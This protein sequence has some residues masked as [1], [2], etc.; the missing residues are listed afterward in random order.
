MITLNLIF[1]QSGK[2]AEE[3]EYVSHHVRSKLDE[4][5]RIELERLR[6]LAKQQYELT[7]GKN[8]SKAPGHLDHSNPDS[9]EISDLQ[10]L[11]YKVS[12]LRKLRSCNLNFHNVQWHKNSRTVWLNCTKNKNVCGMSQLNIYITEEYVRMYKK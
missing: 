11:I 8:V 9:F 1:F 2:I 3:L 12:K 6:H 7:R 4:L 10:R 5:K